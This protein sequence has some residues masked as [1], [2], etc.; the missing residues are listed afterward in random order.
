MLP[1]PFD[2]YPL[3]RPLFFSLDPE[4][5]HKLAVRFLKHG[6]FPACKPSHDPVLACQLGGLKFAH[7]LGL[8]AGFDKHAEVVGQT[9]NLGFSFTE[10]GGVTPVPQPGNP[11]PRLFR[12]TETQAIIN[13]FG[14]NSV[15][16]D[17]FRQ[18]LAAYRDMKTDTGI[19]GINLAKN[20][21][22]I[23]AADDYVRGIQNFAP[24]ADFLTLNI[25]SPNTPGLRG[26]QERG[27]LTELL[28]RARE[29]L[30]QADKKPLLFL[31]I[32]PDI[33]ETQARDIAEVSLLCGIDAMIV[34]NTTTSRPASVPP[35]MAAQAGG[36][37]G[38]PL[39]DI[40][41]KILGQMYQLTGGKIPLVGCGGIFTGADAYAKIRAGASLLQLYTALIYEGPFVIA[42]ITT[43]LAALL[44]RDGYTSLADAVGAD[45]K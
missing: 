43:E 15:G 20:K 12:L 23:D 11:S 16:A 39:F 45:F 18:R 27:S 44:K 31:K 19:V 22:T 1:L 35:A 17:I 34:G 38:K 32:A 37:S 33:T 4:V 6:L 10:I 21:D 9:L 14:F 25:S 42:R 13:R 28:Q 24:F 40:S 29:A 41:T 7:P 30:A 8:A 5:A 26:I 2:I 3:L 36:L